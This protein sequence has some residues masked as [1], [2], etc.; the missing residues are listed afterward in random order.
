MP[1]IGLEGWEYARIIWR[2][3]TQDCSQDPARVL[4]G[5]GVPLFVVN[6]ES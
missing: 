3:K 1:V 4:H 2:V 5:H 6:A